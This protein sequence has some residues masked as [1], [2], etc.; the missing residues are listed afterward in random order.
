MIEQVKAAV[1]ERDLPSLHFAVDSLRFK[2]RMTYEQIRDA[3][4]V[5]EFTWEDLMEMLDE[6]EMR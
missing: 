2:H 3:A 1:A 4:G 5:G 6:E